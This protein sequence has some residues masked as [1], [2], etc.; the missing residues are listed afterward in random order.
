[1][2]KVSMFKWET[3]EAAWYGKQEIYSFSEIKV[4]CNIK[5]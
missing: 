3:E 1:M 2:H 5:P 4:F